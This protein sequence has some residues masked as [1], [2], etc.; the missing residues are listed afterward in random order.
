MD[1]TISMPDTVAPASLPSSLL[2]TRERFTLCSDTHLLTAI[3]ATTE[4][5]PIRDSTAL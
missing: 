2:V 3:L 1:S 5:M 4:A